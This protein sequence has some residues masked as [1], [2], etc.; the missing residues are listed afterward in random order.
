MSPT[1]EIL[2]FSEVLIPEVVEDE[3]PKRKRFVK[4]TEEE[5]IAFLSEQGYEDPKGNGEKFHAFYESKGW[6]VGKNPMKDWKAATRTWKFSK[7]V[8]INGKSMGEVGKRILTQV[9]K[10]QERYANNG[11][12]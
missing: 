4:P 1:S 11:T 5:V 9:E 2:P 10:I 3:K 8:V 12:A 7:P 6:M